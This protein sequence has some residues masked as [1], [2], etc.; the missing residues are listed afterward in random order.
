MKPNTC[1]DCFWYESIGDSAGECHRYPPINDGNNETTIDE[2]PT[3]H[4]DRLVCGEFKK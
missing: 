4:C 3:V 1:A 2:G